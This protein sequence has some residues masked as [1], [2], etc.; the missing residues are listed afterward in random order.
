MCV[1]RS[2]RFLVVHMHRLLFERPRLLG[3][4]FLTA[5]SGLTAAAYQTGDVWGA[6]T[7]VA[8][9]GAGM[10]AGVASARSRQRKAPAPRSAAVAD[11]DDIARL[12]EANAQLQQVIEHASAQASDAAEASQAKS[13][14]LATMAHEIRTPMTA[15]LGY[16]DLL[17]V[18]GDRS[19]A[20]SQRLDYI[21]TIKRNGEHLLALIND[22]LDLSKIEAGKMTVERLAFR[23]VQIF[24][25]VL[26]LLSVRASARGLRLAIEYL[27]PIPE[28]IESDPTRL[29]QV[30]V[31]LI[32]NAIKFTDSG[33][34]TL[35]VAYERAPVPQLSIAVVDTG[36]GMTAEQLDR[37][38][39]PFEQADASV[40]RR[41]G[42]SGLGL[43]I[44]RQL[45]QLLG[46]D[47][48]V[49]SEPG[50]GS[51][52]TLRVATGP[53]A[54]ERLICPAVASSAPHEPTP[55]APVQGLPLAGVRVLLAE[56]G[57]DNR[58][59]IAHHLTKAGAIVRSV[60]NGKAALD[61]LTLGNGAQ[62]RLPS[63][64]DVLVTDMEM[65]ELDGYTLA[66]TLRALGWPGQ[67]IALTAHAMNGDADRC[68]AA[69]CHG[70]ASKPIDRAR[71]IDLCRQAT[72]EGESSRRAA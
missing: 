33:S 71:L 31:N 48:T 58:R 70:Y 19:R 27:T 8:A 10:G 55:L 24:L 17:A 52:F 39:Q 18:E 69:G 36:I 51:T 54:A 61:K 14:F 32:G 7:A 37:L 4:T 46:G 68:L 41:Y 20:P 30:L 29:R 62:L 72:C 63:D 40:A 56:D 5:L 15:I 2:R 57:D 64:V 49:Q 45:A 43:L 16:A 12:A 6:V 67:I 34:V 25:D 13:A 22:I 1:V 11:D 65:P 9:C 59:L 23:P 53:V 26:A 35:R 66:R 60:A 38:F 42:G 50:R 47:I 3:L 28:A 21:D 44:S